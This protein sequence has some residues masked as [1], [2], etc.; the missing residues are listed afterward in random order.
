MPH[1][2]RRDAPTLARCHTGD[3]VVLFAADEDGSLD[4]VVVLHPV[5]HR[6]DLL[7]ERR[8]QRVHGGRW[9]HARRGRGGL[10]G[11]ASRPEG[12]KRGTPGSSIRMIAI[13]SLTSTLK[14]EPSVDSAL[15]ATAGLRGSFRIV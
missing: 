10:Y 12:Q 6:L 5:D 7:L 11:H 1:F 14:I 9:R 4:T 3:K 13:P 15:A 8:G 2:A